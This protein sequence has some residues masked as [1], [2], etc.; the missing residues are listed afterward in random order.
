MC[1]VEQIIGFLKPVGIDGA[2]Y[3]DGG[4]TSP[5][6]VD[7]ARKLGAKLIHYK[8]IQKHNIP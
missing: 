8:S 6:S 7:I 4:A 1:G 5:T 3:G 2:L